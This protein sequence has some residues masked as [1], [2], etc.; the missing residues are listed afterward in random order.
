M[1]TVANVSG[2]DINPYEEESYPSRWEVY[3]LLND[4]E[5]IYIRPVKKEDLAL[6]RILADQ[7]S[8][9][10]IY[11]AHFD[12]ETFISKGAD[13]KINI[14]YTQLM[15]FMALSNDRPLA[16]A[17][18][19]ITQDNVAEIAFAVV[20]GY[21]R[22]G[23][24]TLLLENLVGYAKEY[25]V[26]YFVAHIDSVSSPIGSVLIESGLTYTIKEIDSGA[27]ITLD[28]EITNEF[29]D[30]RDERE[31][32]AE[33]ASMAY[34]LS[35][36]S[37]AVV[38]AGRKP[39]GVGH[40]I[41]R[42]LLSQ[43]FTGTVYPVNPHARS[44]CG[45][46]A[47][48]SLTQVPDQIDMAVI[49]VQAGNVLAVVEDAAKAKV[50]AL[51]IVSSGFGELG[52]EGSNMQSEILK[53]ARQHGIRI[54]GPN[55]LGVSNTSPDVRLDANF[56]PMP[57][58]RGPIALASQSGAVGVV[59]LDQARIA[60]LGVSGFVSMG[61]KIDVSSNDLLC[62]WED[63]PGTKVVALYLES[64]GNPIK[65]SRI[66]KRVGKKKP[67]VVLKG[68]KSKAGAR[69][70]LSHTASAT[71]K[72]ITV[73]TLLASSGVIEAATLEELIDIVKI[74]A[75]AKLPSGK[76]VALVGNSGGP[77]ILA[78]DACSQYGLGV[79]E[80]TEDVQEK[81]S[82]FLPPASA[83]A[84]P[85]DITA[86]GGPDV[87]ENVLREL[88]LDPN[89]DIILVVSTS[90][91]SLSIDQA[92][93]VINRVIDETDK[94]I[95]AC[96]LGG[97]PSSLEQNNV[98][99][100]ANPDNMP[101]FP[102]LTSPE[103]AAIGLSKL[104]EYSIFREKKE[105]RA[106][107]MGESNIHLAKKLVADILKNDIQET[108]LDLETAH[109]LMSYFDVPIVAEQTFATKSELAA[110]ANEITYPVVLK[111]GG[112]SI[113][114]KSDVG[115]V[116]LDIKD[117]DSLINAF[118]DMLDRLGN[119]I[120]PVTVQ[121]MVAQGIETIV[122]LNNDP[123]FGPTIMFGLGGIATDLLKDRAF[124]IPPLGKEDIDKLI[125]S[126]KS[127]PL[128]YG[129]RGSEPVD[130]KSLHKVIA[131]VANLALA[132][133]EVAEIDLNPVIVSPSGS[134]AVDL[135]VKLRQSKGGPDALMRKLKSL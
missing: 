42:K 30:K 27:K 117:K 130:V 122:G 29:L 107:H 1:L 54:V 21:Q 99:I 106:H 39:G 18:F 129:Y 120:L 105:V 82:S 74:A 123:H 37:V 83:S 44:V 58:A 38:G 79:P 90:L 48:A 31:R 28:L 89:V 85:V 5:P 15:A 126:I 80:L 119:Q 57:A 59:L 71:T 69:G 77:L 8:S 66:A 94:P 62:Y 61:N 2:N 127:A 86:D 67:I 19:A 87:L 41:V 125:S 104:L 4:G 47:F 124:A 68:G 100:S 25:G 53:L 60:G 132:I 16:I 91:I 45:V 88:S 116:V 133:P 72:E 73:Q 97:Q 75:M 24:A 95:A 10:D 113:I 112:N 13:D 11:S 109:K 103:R 49:A 63:D 118:S 26:R 115:G 43:D 121:T 12:S 81:L 135:K 70:A 92:T 35:P 78:A 14:D 55:C 40:E 128:L 110:A 134:I 111:A 7:F 36:Q 23:V 34:I 114:H 17:K 50:K 52:E 102:V 98:A 101:K 3:G 65:F 20:D 84:N 22:K 32:L 108:W 93:A 46:P 56:A 9:P 96:F 6:L 131:G 76:N 51:V 64:F 33:A